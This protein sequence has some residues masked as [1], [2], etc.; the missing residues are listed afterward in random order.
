M[1]LFSIKF[2]QSD[3]FVGLEPKRVSKKLL[4]EVNHQHDRELWLL[5]R[6]HII[7]SD[8]SVDRSS[9]VIA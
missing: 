3:V 5:G 4:D 8:T 7:I 9:Q 6:I 2:R 1:E